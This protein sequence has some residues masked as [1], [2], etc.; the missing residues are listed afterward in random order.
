MITLLVLTKTLILL[1][2]GNNDISGDILDS[3]RNYREECRSAIGGIYISIRNDIK[4]EQGFIDFLTLRNRGFSAEIRRVENKLTTLE[5]KLKVSGYDVPLEEQKQAF[6]IKRQE[7]N[8]L[9]S[10][11]SSRIKKKQNRIA[12]L[13]KN[14][15]AYNKVAS[16]V[17]TISHSGP[18]NKK[19]EN[20]AVDISYKHKCQKYK[21]I[22]PL[23]PKEAKALRVVANYA[24]NIRPNE[25]NLIPCFKYS[26]MLPPQNR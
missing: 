1:P 5:K 19:E 20:Y 11:N 24:Q 16:K 7:L 3:G 12:V 9:K 2:F 6:I 18:K 23:P 17:F 26:Q 25:D 14:I 4:T 10:E 13:K 21:F 15:N 22:C 8:R